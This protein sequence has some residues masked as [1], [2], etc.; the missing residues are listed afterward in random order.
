LY[1]LELVTVVPMIIGWTRWWLTHSWCGHGFHSS[2]LL[3]V[4]YFPIVVN[5]IYR[6][7]RYI[8][9]IILDIFFKCTIDWWYISQWIHFKVIVGLNA[10]P[11]IF[12]TT[13]LLYKLDTLLR[14][15]LLLS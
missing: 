3:T 2:I 11:F 15:M 6:V 10:I 14:I 13:L 1:K 12:S 5:K 9:I 7:Y 8:G 4:L